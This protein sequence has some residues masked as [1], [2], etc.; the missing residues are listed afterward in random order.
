M[1]HS[2]DHTLLQRM[3]F[4]DPDRRT[5]AHDDACIQI[6]S[7]PD[8]FLRAVSN[9]LGIRNARCGLE[10]PLQKGD[11]KYATTVGFLD[12]FIAWSETFEDHDWWCNADC[13]CHARTCTCQ[14]TSVGPNPLRWA[15][16]SMVVEVKTRITSLGDLLRQV[17]L[18]REY[19]KADEYV[20]WSLSHEDGRYAKLL[21]DQGYV[22]LAGAL[23]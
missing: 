4:A 10:V 2:F 12:A 7:D 11:G 9:R 19:R 23:P 21:G 6:A 3:G 8:R 16:V 14:R 17:N 5:P 22:L 1:T 20:V 15:D 18:Y 13:I